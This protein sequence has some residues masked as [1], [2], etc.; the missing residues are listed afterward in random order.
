MKVYAF[1]KKKECIMEIE[2]T[3][4]AKQAF[5]GGLIQSVSLTDELDLICNDEGK[6]GTG[7][8]MAA[9]IEDGKVVDIIY[10]NF[11]VCR[12]NNNGEFVSIKES[13]VKVIREKLKPI[14]LFINNTV[15]LKPRKED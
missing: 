14:S 11:L 5:V 9:W 1:T 15:Y 7:V 8:P 6:L 10:G 12:Y 2:N 3:L 4:E 13:D